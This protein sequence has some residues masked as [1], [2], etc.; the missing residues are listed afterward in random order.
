[1]F[2]P[3]RQ[4]G[5]LWHMFLQ[6][7]YMNKYSALLQ[8]DIIDRQGYTLSPYVWSVQIKV[9]KY[10]KLVDLFTEQNVWILLYTW[11]LIPWIAS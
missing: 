1:M 4:R 8:T 3:G 7:Q 5:G 9:D 6:V 11:N 10:I 2:P